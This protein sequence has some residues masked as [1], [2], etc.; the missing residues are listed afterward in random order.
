M[1]V[2]ST[3]EFPGLD[4]LRYPMIVGRRNH[5]TGRSVVLDEIVERRTL[6]SAEFGALAVGYL[7]EVTAF[8]RRLSGNHAEADDLVQ[9]VFERAFR[10]RK[11]LE[12]ASRCRA[13]LFQIARNRVID[14]QR[15]Q[16]A[17][18][19]LRLVKSS[20]RLAP[21]PAVSA[22]RVERADAGAVEDALRSLSE[23][24][25][26]AVLLADVWGCSYDEIAEVLEVPIGTVRSRI[27]RA[28]QRLA[29]TLSDAASPEL[30]KG[31]LP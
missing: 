28:R 30:A 29:E 12:D 5:S 24:Q 26:H 7:G 8:V 27:A 2:A 21:E 15:A 11:G 22:E 3:L 13:W 31:R 1:G 25:R 14:W 6:D 16:N 23:D 9:D 10:A 4:R 19:E 17:R 18:P 20:D